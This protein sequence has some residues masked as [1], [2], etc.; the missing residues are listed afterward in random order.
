MEEVCPYYHA[1]DQ[2]IQG[3]KNFLS[4]FKKVDRNDHERCCPEQNVSR[5]S[6]DVKEPIQFKVP[7]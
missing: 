6:Q 4:I 2:N 1:P 5:I 7:W 3:T